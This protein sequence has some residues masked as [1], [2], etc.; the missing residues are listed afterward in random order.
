MQSKT[1]TYEAMFVMDAGSGDYE[2]ANEPINRVLQRNEAEVIGIKPWDERR[3]AY[4]IK[5]RRRGMYLLT[6]F[7]VDPLKVKDIERDV[8]LAEDILR[9]LVLRCENFSEELV[10]AETP[11]TGGKRVDDRPGGARG[12]FGD[13]R[14]G[15]GG[16]RGRDDDSRSSRDDS[17]KKSSRGDSDKKPSRDDSDKRS[18]RDDSDKRSSRGD[19]D[20]KKTGRDDSDD[21]GNDDS[22]SDDG[23]ET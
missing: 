1:K 21:D 12:R 23:D 13:D 6:Y 14:R 4:E 22:D 9:V 10:E 18:S 8:Q 7:K 16:R 15:G 20:A 11:A 17:D 19:S 2:A 3:L 5:G